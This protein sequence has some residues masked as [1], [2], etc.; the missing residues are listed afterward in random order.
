MTT[1]MVLSHGYRWGKHRAVGKSLR[2]VRMNLDGRENCGRT[3]RDCK[4]PAPSRE[5]SA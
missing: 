3:C 5:G 2:I 1:T 4:W